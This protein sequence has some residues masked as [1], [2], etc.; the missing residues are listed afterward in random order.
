MMPA[1]PGS[2]GQQRL[3][4]VAAGTADASG[5]ITLKFDAVTSSQVWTGSVFSEL[6]SFSLAAFQVF[7]DAQYMGAFSGFGALTDVQASD[8]NVVT[9]TAQGLTANAQVRLAWMGR[10]DPV[11]GVGPV[12][13]FVSGPVGIRGQSLLA[14]PLSLASIAATS[15]VTVF[16]G[17]VTAPSYQLAMDFLCQA[18]PASPW[19]KLSIIGKDGQAGNTLSLEHYIALQTN[20]P[21]AAQNG[22]I[23]GPGPLE[24]SWLTM[25]LHNYDSASTT[26][27]FELFQ[28]NQTTQASR[29]A[30]VS[31][32]ITGTYTYGG[33]TFSTPVG[34]PAALI[35][36]CSPSLTIAAGSTQERIE[37]LRPGRAQLNVEQVG[38]AFA[39]TVALYCVQPDFATP[40][41]L[42]FGPVTIPASGVLTVPATDINLPRTPVIVTL[43]NG[44]GAA[45]A[46]TYSLIPERP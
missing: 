5:S 42:I 16:D 32:N 30:N 10:T 44:S 25:L 46:Y 28:N 39:G 29:L 8:G 13:P 7:R 11:G 23:C 9:V 14:Q 35:D 31:N 26:A 2:F 24:A 3:Y 41:Q 18:V 37:P 38:A 43:T 6:P 17:P 15:T 1:Q 45:Q 36:G 12:S 27:D 20:A 21:V 33:H 22:L 40:V 34:D 4:K 19:V